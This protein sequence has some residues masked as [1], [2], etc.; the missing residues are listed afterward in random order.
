[1]AGAYKRDGSEDLCLG[2]FAYAQTVSHGLQRDIQFSYG[3]AG[4]LAV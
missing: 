2:R 4:S 1:M 3:H